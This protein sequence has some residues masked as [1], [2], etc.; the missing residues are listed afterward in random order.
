MMPT[1]QADRIAALEEELSAWKFHARQA[2]DLANLREM[3]ANGAEFL[4]A[5]MAAAAEPLEGL[6][7]AEWKAEIAANAP[8]IAAA[9]DLLGALK[10]AMAAINAAIQLGMAEAQGHERTAAKL[11]SQIEAARANARAAIAKASP[12]PPAPHSDGER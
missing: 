4:L 6:S 10:G 2:V 7:A 9:P 3:R 1:E 12:T 5:L 8:L 11:D